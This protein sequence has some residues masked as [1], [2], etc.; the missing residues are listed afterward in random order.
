MFFHTGACTEYPLVQIGRIWA[1][2]LEPD[3][4]PGGILRDTILKENAIALQ[5]R[6]AAGRNKLAIMYVLM[7]D[8]ISRKSQEAVM[9]RASEQPED[10]KNAG[11]HEAFQMSTYP[12]LLLTYLRTTHLIPATGV[13]PPNPHTCL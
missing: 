7:W 3:N 2:D 11:D 4:D 12:L 5:N 10:G 1:E 6:N 13:C 8:T 9:Q